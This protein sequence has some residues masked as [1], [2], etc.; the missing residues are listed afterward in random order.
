MQSGVRI[1]RLRI[2]G[3]SNEPQRFSVV[4]LGFVTL[5][6]TYLAEPID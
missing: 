6:S 4:T 1:R 5:V 2:E 3:W